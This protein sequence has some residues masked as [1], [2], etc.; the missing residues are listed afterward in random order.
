MSFPPV[1]SGDQSVGKAA[2]VG[3]RIAVAVLIVIG[4]GAILTAAS[5]YLKLKLVS[6]QEPIIMMNRG[7]HKLAWQDEF[8]QVDIHM[9][10]EVHNVCIESSAVFNWTIDRCT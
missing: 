3:L 8:V 1:L 7:L 9:L 6:Q 10:V 2:S 5:F 4:V